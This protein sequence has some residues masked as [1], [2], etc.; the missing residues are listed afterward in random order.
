MVSGGG[1]VHG[2]I[3]S[4]A[5]GCSLATAST[6]PSNGRPRHHDTHLCRLRQVAPN[7]DG[8]VDG[9]LTM[10]ATLPADAA[11][12]RS[13]AGCAEVANWK[14]PQ[15]SVIDS[16]KGNERDAVRTRKKHRMTRG[17]K[18]RTAFQIRSQ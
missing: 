3:N 9:G 14:Q 6:S 10:S 7:S 17:L 11:V 12:D 4:T 18:L 5:R 15:D 8:G 16:G 13:L 1:L 2:N